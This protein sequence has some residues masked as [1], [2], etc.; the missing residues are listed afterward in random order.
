MKPNPHPF[1]F[2]AA[3]LAVA[4]LTTGCPDKLRK[5]KG[6]AEEAERELT[7]IQREK[8]A[9]QNKIDKVAAWERLPPPRPD[10]AIQIQK[11]EIQREQAFID[12][13]QQKMLPKLDEINKEIKELNDTELVEVLSGVTNTF[14]L[15]SGLLTSKAAG[16]VSAKDALQQNTVQKLDGLTNIMAQQISLLD[17]LA[18]L[19]PGPDRDNALNELSMLSAL[20]SEIS[21]EPEIE[22]AGWMAEQFEYVGPLPVLAGSHFPQTTIVIEEGMPATLAH[23]NDGI[24]QPGTEI[25]LHLPPD[26]SITAPI[27]AESP[28]L[29]LAIEDNHP[30]NNTLRIRVVGEVEPGLTNDTIIATFHGIQIGQ[31]AGL[32]SSCMFVNPGRASKVDFCVVTE[33]LPAFNP[34]SLTPGGMEMSWEGRGT[35]QKSAEVLGPYT[36]APNQTNP[37]IV[38]LNDPSQFF[39]IAR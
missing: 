24:L 28:N 1:I 14:P 5:L 21:F 12:Q 4:V 15:L 10:G 34:P 3:V 36:N 13:L 11:N 29:L 9:L 32:V 23:L 39:R 37:Q 35:L 20:S 7:G 27:S 16:I 2:L 38:P 6:K 8:A 31:Q 25:I 22:T 33:P 26:W 30:G 18:A 19:P 17:S